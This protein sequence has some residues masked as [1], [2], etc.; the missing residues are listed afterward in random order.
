MCHKMKFGYRTAS[1]ILAQVQTHAVPKRFEGLRRI[2]YCKE[3][4]CWHLT[5]KPYMFDR[6]SHVS[7]SI[8]N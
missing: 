4:D 1:R 7:T 8:Q 5:S 3:C 6:R 2:Y